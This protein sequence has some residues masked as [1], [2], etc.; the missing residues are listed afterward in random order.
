MDETKLYNEKI[1]SEVKLILDSLT[2]EQRLDI[3]LNY[4]THCGSTNPDCQCWN[5]E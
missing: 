5:D 2:D 1:I 4:C 3:I